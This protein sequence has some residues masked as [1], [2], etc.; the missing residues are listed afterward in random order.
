MTTAVSPRVGADPGKWS[1]R[2]PPLLQWR[3]EIARKT[4][5]VIPPIGFFLCQLSEIADE[6]N[7]TCVSL[8]VYIATCSQLKGN[9]C[10]SKNERN[11]T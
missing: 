11:G 3:A 1:A 6:E 8:L 7:R 4:G 5:T 2:T 10:D 9:I